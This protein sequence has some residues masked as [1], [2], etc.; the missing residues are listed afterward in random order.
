M[1][2]TNVEFQNL[3]EAVCKIGD[4][5]EE[6]SKK[7]D[8]LINSRVDDAEIAIVELDEDRGMQSADIESAMIEL[9]E[10]ITGGNTNG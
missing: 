5:Q 2:V 10:M 3:V 4:R 7:I 1:Y 8:K 9:A 6:I